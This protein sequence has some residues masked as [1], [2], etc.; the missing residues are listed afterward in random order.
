MRIL[1]ATGVFFPDVGGPA[2][3]VRKIAERFSAEGLQPLVL[4]YGDDQAGADF[5]FEVIRISRKSNKILQW[6]FYL[7]R[8]LVLARRVDLIYAFDPTAAGLPARFAAKFFNKPFVIRVGGDPI[9]ERQ[10]EL[11]KV[12][13]PLVDY[14]NQ[15]LYKKDKPLLYRLIKFVLAGADAIVLYSQS[16]KDFYI[17]YFAVDPNRVRIIKNPVSRKESALPALPASPVILFAGRFVKYKNLV[18]VFK[19]FKSLDVVAGQPRLLL[20]GKGPEQV[21]LMSLAQELGIQDSIQFMGSIPQ[22][23]LFDQIRKS[24]ICIGPAL[25]EFN[26]NFILEA[27]SLGKPVLL[28]RGHGLSVDLPE[29]FLFDPLSQGSLEAKLS[30]LLIPENYRRAVKTV[31]TLEM[32]QTWEKVTDFHSALI[33]EVIR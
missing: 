22:I 10:A 4:C 9:W 8:A 31:D 13:M 28:S 33:R 2:I 25:S 27:L 18:L 24:A 30:Y 16:F 7:W 19:A 23:E 21:A 26:P 14:Y 1:L 17:K 32:N 6:A 12:F 29:E 15:G 20:I 3:H 11:G 5:P